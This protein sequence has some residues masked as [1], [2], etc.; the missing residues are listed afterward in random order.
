MIDA[1][2]KFLIPGLWDMHFHLDDP[3][4]WPTRMTRE[5]KELI[6][7][8]LVVNGVTGLR[9]MAGSLEQL[10]SGN[11]RSRSVKY[12]DHASSLRAL[13]SMGLRPSGQAL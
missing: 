10:Q 5:D 11:R 2:G 3:E 1:T 13:S 6:F 8:L 7:P 9:D 12:S 4:M